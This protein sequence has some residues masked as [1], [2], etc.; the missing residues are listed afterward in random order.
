MQRA[1]C[2]Q[3]A[4]WKPPAHRRQR[5]NYRYR[6][7]QPTRRQRAQSMATGKAGKEWRRAQCRQRQRRWPWRWQ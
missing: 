6:F 7:I 5:N 2:T 3:Q 1:R 4:L